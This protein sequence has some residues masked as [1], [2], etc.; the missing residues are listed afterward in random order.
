MTVLCTQAVLGAPIAATV[1]FGAGS[2]VGTADRVATF[3]GLTQFVEV[4]L[5]TY[6]EGGLSIRTPA[7][8]LSGYP[9]G[10]IP[11]PCTGVWYPSGGFG[12][13]D[14]RSANLARISTVDGVRMMAIE[15]TFYS[16]NPAGFPFFVWETYRGGVLVSAGEFI[17]PNP[18][19]VIGWQFGYEIDEL[20]V[21]AFTD[22]SNGSWRDNALGLDNLR[23]HLVPEP[24]S[25]AL[26]ALGFLGLAVARR[27]RIESIRPG[28]WDVGGGGRIR[29]SPMD[30]AVIWLH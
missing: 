9:C 22:P 30:P 20:R 13:F 25:L 17:A 1:T 28:R 14:S 11:A 23:I 8:S 16:G 18:E 3:D 24:S 12:L 19:T 5:S 26:I 27:R 15:F 10:G 7:P 6:V 29:H 4:D 21:G 2:A